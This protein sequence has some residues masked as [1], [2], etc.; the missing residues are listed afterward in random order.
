M[1]TKAPSLAAEA[2][3]QCYH[4]PPAAL[5]EYTRYL[6]R[7]LITELKY[8]RFGRQI[9]FSLPG[10]W[11]YRV[12]TSLLKIMPQKCEETIQGQRSFKW[13]RPT[14]KKPMS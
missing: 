5:K 11:P 9:I 7:V 3:I 8:A 13:F 6:N 10:T 14:A 4:K 12:L 1:R 2:V